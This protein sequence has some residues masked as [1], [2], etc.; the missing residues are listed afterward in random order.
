MIHL[1]KVSRE[2]YDFLFDMIKSRPYYVNIHHKTPP[3]IIDHIKFIESN[4]YEAWFII[5]D[6]D[7]RI[8]NCY[9]TKNNEIGLFLMDGWRT[10]HA[11]SEALRILMKYGGTRKYYANISISN[12]ASQYFFSKNGFNPISY[13]YERD[14]HG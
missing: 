3:K 7:I 12:E 1:K 13:I 10:S 9:I 8:G 11:G 14:Y 4:P 2:D 5:L 6:D